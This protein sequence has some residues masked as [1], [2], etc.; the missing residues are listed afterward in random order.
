MIAWNEWLQYRSEGGK[1]I[2]P[3]TAKRQLKTLSV[4]TEKEAVE[5]I[6][7][8]IHNGWTGLFEVTKQP[9]QK[10]AQTTVDGFTSAKFG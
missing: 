10:P 3:S 2:T 8:S 9:G 6:E 5:R 1:K 7:R 4:L